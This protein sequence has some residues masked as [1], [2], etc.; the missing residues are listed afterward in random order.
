MVYVVL[1][2]FGQYDGGAHIVAI[3]AKKE[4]AEREAARQQVGKKYPEYRVEPHR[5]KKV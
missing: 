3:Y 2:D 5:V 4:S 1:E